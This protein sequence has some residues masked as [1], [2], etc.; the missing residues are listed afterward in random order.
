MNG[1]FPAKSEKSEH[2]NISVISWPI[3][4]KF[5]MHLDSGYT[6]W[7]KFPLFLKFKM[8]AAVMLNVEL[9]PYLARQWRYLHQIWRGDRYCPSECH[10]PQITFFC[11]IQDVDGWRYLEFGFCVMSVDDICVIFCLRIDVGHT[12]VTAD[13]KSIFSKLK[14]VA[15]CIKFGMPIQ[16]DMLMASTSESKSEVE[17]QYGGYGTDITFH[18][19]YF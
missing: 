18:R 10:G 6:M 8:A 11:K 7:P 2:C 19:T 12:C 16:N 9:W 3:C 1:H 14:I 4:T 13:A 15:L 17:F 5:G